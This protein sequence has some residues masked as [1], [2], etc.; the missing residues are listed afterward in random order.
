MSPCMQSVVERPALPALI[1]YLGAVLCRHSEVRMETAVGHIAMTAL[2]RQSMKIM[3]LR[4]ETSSV[5]KG[6]IIS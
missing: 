1:K 3:S 6:E 4:L 2:A 5:S